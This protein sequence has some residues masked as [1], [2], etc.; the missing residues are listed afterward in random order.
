MRGRMKRGESFE[1]G[2]GWSFWNEV[3]STQQTS[4]LWKCFECQ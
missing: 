2:P 4:L 3:N 1:A